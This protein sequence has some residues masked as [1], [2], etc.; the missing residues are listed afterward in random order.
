M[1]KPDTFYRKLLESHSEQDDKVKETDSINI[2][3]HYFQIGWAPIQIKK[4]K[5]SSVNTN[6]LINMP[7]HENQ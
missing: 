7:I 4:K 5:Q 1:D 6:P 3:L 2:S